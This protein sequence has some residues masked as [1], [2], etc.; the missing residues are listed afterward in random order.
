VKAP[1]RLWLL[2]WPAGLAAGAL[3]LTLVL[4]S[5]HEDRPVLTGVLGL[6]AG[7]S[8]VG[9]GLVARARAR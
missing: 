3:E 8:F 2:Y 6:V 9:S 4:T 7:W 5:N 1:E